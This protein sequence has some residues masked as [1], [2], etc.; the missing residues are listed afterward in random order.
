MT[1]EVAKQFIGQLE[2]ER[3][4]LAQLKDQRDGIEEQL[5]AERLYGQDLE[6]LIKRVSGLK[7]LDQQIGKA[8]TEAAAE[9]KEL[10]LA[11]SE[12]AALQVRLQ[13]AEQKLAGLTRDTSLPS[14]SH[15]YQR[16]TSLLKAS[17][18]R[19]RQELRLAERRVD[20]MKR[21]H[22]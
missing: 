10:S 3:D 7:S 8:L 5:N 9:A 2:H 17:I 16:E 21:R 18:D 14:T 1:S 15:T 20:E 12:K 13:Q 4:R 6:M 19:E 11:R 22:V